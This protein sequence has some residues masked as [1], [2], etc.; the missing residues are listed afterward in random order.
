M[1]DLGSLK[2]KNISGGSLVVRGYTMSDQETVDVMNQSGPSE[3]RFRSW[4]TA[5]QL[6]R[7]PDPSIGAD[8]IGV[9][10][11]A[12]SLELSECRRPDRSTWVGAPP[13]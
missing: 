9:L 3:F 8:S 7:N 4:H 2:I 1:W 11:A 10:V 13:S 5:L 6:C 12:G